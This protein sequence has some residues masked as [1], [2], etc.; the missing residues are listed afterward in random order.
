MYAN[1]GI[2]VLGSGMQSA[3]SRIYIL[4]FFARP[5]SHTVG[6]QHNYPLVPIRFSKV[7]VTKCI[8]NYVLSLN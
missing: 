4:V 7:L 5:E 1:R 8:G 2:E 6:Q 3:M